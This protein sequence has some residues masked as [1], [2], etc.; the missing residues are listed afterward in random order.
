MKNQK[1]IVSKEPREGRIHH[2]IN[3]Q[4][5]SL[6]YQ[7]PLDKLAPNET[8]CDYLLLN[9]TK[10]TAYLIE[11]KG[12]KIRKAIDQLQ[13]GEQLFKE[14]L[15]GFRIYYRIVF[16]KASTHDIKS[17]EFRKFKEQCGNKLNYGSQYMV[18][19]I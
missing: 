8:C 18:E 14:N 17:M 11:L 3:P 15:E 1:I 13:G 19:E 16:S 4:G 7:Y 2:A 6:V 12:K 10:R 5:R 9:G